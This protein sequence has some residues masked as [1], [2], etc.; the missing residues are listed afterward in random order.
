M[1]KPIPLS[2]MPLRPRHWYILGVASAEQLIGGALSTLVGIM[3]PLIL[4]LGT[5]HLS[6]L[7]QGL[8]GAAGLAGIALGSLVMGQL[9]DKYGYL[10]L[11]RLCPALI[12][13]GSVG[14]FFS[15]SVGLLL[16]WLFLTGLGVGG[17]Y[18]L[19]SGY[20]SELMPARWENFMV[21]LAKA[22][23][24]LGFVGGAAVGYF[25]LLADP[26]ARVWPWLILFIA[27]LGLLTL[28]LRIRWYQSPRW[29]LARGELAKAEKAAREFLGPQAEVRPKPQEMAVKQLAW[30]DMFR[31]KAL[32]KVILAGL[33]WACEGLGVYGFGVFLPIL[34][35]ALGIE[36]G[37]LEG[38]PRILA[39]VRT[40]VFINIF[41]GA[42]FGLGLAVINRLNPVR[43]MGWCFI[44]CALMLLVLLAGYQLHWAAWISL[45]AFITFETAL[46]AGPH[47]VTF[48]LPSRIYSIEERGGGMGIA[49][50]CGKVGAV[51]GVFFMPL[52][53]HW[54][55]IACV[56]LV[57]ILV[58]LIGAAI[59]FIYGRKLNLL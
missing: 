44:I 46:N 40:T 9:M 59:S 45:I 12:T 27:A 23:S 19:D 16:L 22:T 38:I 39:S 15:D 51:A 58:Q 13:A 33:T 14:V 7:S 20:I 5:P 2:E 57:S 29:L 35:M 4:L 8:M 31:G 48:I 21:G 52:L 11:F 3:I 34:V 55:G 53:L 43:L 6:A 41:I 47:L 17:G 28:L 30:Y 50:L 37:G 54:G 18:S 25:A 24:S 32:D 26:S 10:F 49:T 1:E 56:L 42:G 36:S